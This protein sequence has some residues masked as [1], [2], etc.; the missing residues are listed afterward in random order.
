MA[1]SNPCIARLLTSAGHLEI[2]SDVAL[3]VMIEKISMTPAK[4]ALASPVKTSMAPALDDRPVVA[5]LCDATNYEGFTILEWADYAKRKSRIA[6]SVCKCNGELKATL[7]KL[8]A[9][10]SDNLGCYD[11]WA[12]ASLPVLPVEPVDA[13][14]DAW[15]EWTGLGCNYGSAAVCP[16][17]EIVEMQLQQQSD[18]TKEYDTR[19]GANEN[20]RPND[21]DTKENEHDQQSD[22]LVEEVPIVTQQWTERPSVEKYVEDTQVQLQEPP[23]V[24]PGAD[25]AAMLACIIE[26]QK[27]ALTP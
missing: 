7:A 1:G 17:N 14:V 2:Y 24:A 4:D 12:G 18:D 20:D 16:K 27:S 25:I 6:S 22:E 26:Q 19:V 21:D 23:D 10:V 8:L 5:R 9:D 3:A 15:S 13:S 11:P